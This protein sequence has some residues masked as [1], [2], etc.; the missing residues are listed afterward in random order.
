MTRRRR[1]LFQLAGLLIGWM[2]YYLIPLA[3]QIVR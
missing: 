3:H 1:T 2:A